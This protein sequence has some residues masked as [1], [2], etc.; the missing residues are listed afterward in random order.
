MSQKPILSK[1]K[2]YGLVV[3]GGTFDLFHKG[4]K[5]FLQRIFDNANTVKVGI[6]SDNFA[7][8]KKT[9]Q[10][11]PFKIRKLNVQNYLRSI[12]DKK[13][14]IIKIEDIYGPLLD[15]NLKAEAIAVTKDTKQNA[16]KIHNKRAELGLAEIETIVVDM[17]FAENGER[18]S[19]SR[20]R[21]GRL[22][23]EGKP[24][25]KTTWL[26]KNLILPDS[27]RPELKMP[28]G[29]II[30]SIPVDINPKQ[31]ITVG[32][33]TTRRFLSENII[34]HLSIVDLKVK[35]NKE[36]Q[37]IQELGFGSKTKIYITANK[38][39]SLNGNLFKLISEVILRKQDSVILINGEEDLAFIPVML[40]SPLGYKIFYG[41]PD[42]GLIES[43]VTEENKN[44]IF[45]LLDKFYIDS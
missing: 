15:K 3:C 17:D 6:T 24:L 27:L 11:E 18:I 22:D 35:R 40:T 32:D 41:Q 7:N 31:I 2:K 10:I 29:K 42:K 9:H 25:Y 12:T 33:I 20:I 21:L 5:A 19:S 28:Y 4:H 14:K 37:D 13:F 34:P 45:N 39:G 1:Q 30:K 16:E 36:F 38:Q 23:R 8:N 43:N 44:I 26:N